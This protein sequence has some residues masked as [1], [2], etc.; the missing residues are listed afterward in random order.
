MKTVLISEFKARCIALLK[1]VD[2]TK[3]SF[4]VTRRGRPLVQIKPIESQ[5][6]SR[7]LGGL[8]STVVFNGDLIQANFSHD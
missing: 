1:E 7:I 8:E 4:V 6:K 2:T 5:S 3:E